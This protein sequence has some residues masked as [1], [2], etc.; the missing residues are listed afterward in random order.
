[1]TQDVHL[2]VAIAVPRRMQRLLVRRV[3]N[4]ELQLV[5]GKKG[6]ARSPIGGSLPFRHCPGLTEENLEEQTSVGVASPASKTEQRS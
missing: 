2:S 1:M 5:W 4:S 6:T 3:A